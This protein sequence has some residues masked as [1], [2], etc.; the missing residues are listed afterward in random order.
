MLAAAAGH[1]AGSAPAGGAASGG[2][3]EFLREVEG[4]MPNL[5]RYARSLT[6]DADEADDVVQDA[7]LA[8]LDKIHLFEPG[9]NLR[10]WLFTITRNTFI[11]HQRRRRIRTHLPLDDESLDLQAP[12][13]QE[14]RVAQGHLAAAYAQL[15]RPHREVL[16]LVVFESMSYEQAAEILEVAVGT[17]RSRLARARATLRTAIG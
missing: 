13:A 6:R 7:L 14:A 1:G 15:P 5:R 11:T 10:A 17:V 9:S 16:A 2:R 8:A 3:R 4:M 12:P